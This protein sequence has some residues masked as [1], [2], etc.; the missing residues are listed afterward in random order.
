[1]QLSEEFTD[2]SFE[3]GDASQGGFEGG[4]LSFERGDPG[5]GVLEGT[6]EPSAFGTVGARGWLEERHGG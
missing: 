5:Q 6:S 1:M 2:L 3:H 4:P